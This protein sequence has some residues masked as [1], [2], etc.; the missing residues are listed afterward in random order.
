MRSITFLQPNRL[1]FGAGCLAE[2]LAYLA[3]LDSP[4]IHIVHSSSLAQVVDRMQQKL[5]ASGCTVT[6]DRAP[7]GEPTIAAFDFALAR[8]RAAIPHASSASAEAVRSISPSFSPP[9]YGTISAS[10]TP[11]A[12]A[13]SPRATATSSA[14]PPPRNRQRGLTQRNPA[15]RSCAVE[16]GRHQSA[17]CSRRRLHRPR[18]YPLVPRAVTACTGLDAL[19]HL[20]E[21]YTNRFAHPLVDLY[22]LEGIALCARFLPRAVRNPNDAEAR[23]GM[24]RASLYGGLCLGPVNTAAVH[25]LAYPLGGE[26]HLPHG[27][28][29]RSFSPPSS[30]ST[31]K[32]HPIVTPPLHERLA[33]LRNPPPSRQHSPA[34]R[35]SSNSHTTAASTPT[36]PTTV[37]IAAPSHI[38]P[39]PR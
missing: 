36:S 33:L 10:R 31:R 26:F 19:T 15:R 2:A 11:S 22:A 4:R 27:L 14:S 29:T 12:S 21:A 23:E 13:C 30:A 7:A 1:T 8:A 34:P 5:L 35:S 24:A 20:I 39:P 38:S 16:E 25:A 18:A 37:S 17:P 9:L 32:P 3:A 28:S 6:T